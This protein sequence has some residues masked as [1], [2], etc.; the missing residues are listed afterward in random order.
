MVTDHVDDDFKE[1]QAVFTSPERADLTVLCGDDK[2][3]L[4]WEIVRHRSGFFAELYDG[5][6]EACEISLSEERN[7]IANGII[8]KTGL[9][10]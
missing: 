9:Q 1:V 7:T 2:Y 3:L 4:D 5:V 6:L 8:R 10:R